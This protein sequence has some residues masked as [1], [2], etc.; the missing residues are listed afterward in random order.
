M[1]TNTIV[2]QAATASIVTPNDATP[3]TNA[4][5]NSP[6]ALFVGTAGDVEVITL[7]G[8]TVVFKNIANGTFMPVQVTHVKAAST[9]ASDIVALF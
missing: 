8:S 3:I 5:F 9:T 4:S 7:G 1:P 2:R 6:A